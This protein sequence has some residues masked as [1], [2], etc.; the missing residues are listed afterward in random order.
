MLGD[1]VQRQAMA[2]RKV[3]YPRLSCPRELREHAAAGLV[4]EGKESVV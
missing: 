4:A 2:A 1:G 3:G